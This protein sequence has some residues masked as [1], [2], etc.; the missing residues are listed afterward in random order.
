MKWPLFVSVLRAVES[1]LLILCYED[2]DVND[3]VFKSVQD[4][5]PPPK[6]NPV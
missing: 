5:P 6:K 1:L 3:N 4:Y 2:E